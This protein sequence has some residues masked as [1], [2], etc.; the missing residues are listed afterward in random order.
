MSRRARG[1]DFTDPDFARNWAGAKAAGLAVGAHHFYRQC[2]G[3]REQAAHF[4]RVLPS[5]PL[6]LPPVIDAEHMGPCPAGTVRLD[7]VAEI[8]IFLDVVQARTGCRPILYVTPDFDST[9][10]HGRFEAARF[11]VR[12]IFLPPFFRQQT[13]V[14]WQYHHD[15]RRGGI[16]GPVDLN[17]FRGDAAALAALI[18]DAGCFAA[19]S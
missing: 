12:S 19:P 13:W 9:Y 4:L 3:G 8:G 1:G 7:P 14:F 15:G 18:R 2:K 10:L 11:W 16:T 6:Q 17:A 5:E